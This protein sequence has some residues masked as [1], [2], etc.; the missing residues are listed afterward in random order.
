MYASLINSSGGFAEF[1]GS[2]GTRHLHVVPPP[3]PMGDTSSARM[4]SAGASPTSSTYEGDSFNIT[5]VESKDAKATAQ[6]VVRQIAEIQKT[7]R[8]RS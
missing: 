6:E 2:A 1:H 7:W 4:G 3:S 5:V 8:R